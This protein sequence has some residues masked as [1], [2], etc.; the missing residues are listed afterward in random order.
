MDTYVEPP[1]KI[2]SKYL[3]DINERILSSGLISNDPMIMQQ[4]IHRRWEKTRFVLNCDPSQSSMDGLTPD[5]ILFSP[6]QYIHHMTHIEHIE[7]ILSGGYLRYNSDREDQYPGIYTIP[8]LF[9]KK[10]CI[11]CLDI[12]IIISLS[13]LHK[14]AWHLNIFENYGNISSNTFDY[15]TLPLYFSSHYT[16]HEF[17]ELVFHYPIPIS[18]IEAIV[19]KQK[20]VDDVKNIVSSS[21]TTNHIPVYTLKDFNNMK[22]YRYIKGL[23]NDL[24]YTNNT[25]NFCYSNL[26]GYD[27]TR[28]TY[29]QIISTLLNSGYSNKDADEII[30]SNS[31]SEIVTFLEQLWKDRLNNPVILPVICHPPYPI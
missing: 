20:Y 8:E 11:N 12:S 9:N 29:N 16:I 4:I 23:Y 15:H 18:Y 21:I 7:D 27:Y 2:K 19:V 22:K 24:G 6:F 5:E 3:P 13:L 14:S 1:K 31:Y 10:P 30:T 26:G 17:G 25:P 28:L